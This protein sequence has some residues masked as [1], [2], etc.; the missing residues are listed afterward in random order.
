MSS[1]PT[2][3]RG[4]TLLAAV[5]AVALALAPAIAEAQR[6]GG[7][8]G[9]RGSRTYSA[10]PPTQT[11]PSTAQ[12]LQRTQ[13][14]PTA[15]ATAARPG[16]PAAATPSPAR[17]GFMGGLMGGLIG[18][19][20]AGM[21]FGGGLFGGLNGFAGF[22]G[23]L[24]Q[25]LLIGGLVYLI[26]RLVRGARAPRPALAGLPQGMARTANAGPGPMPMGGGAAP[27]PS[28]EIGIGDQDYQAF[29]RILQG[30]NDA[31]TRQDPEAMR[32]I[33][34][35]EMVAAFGEDLGKLQAKG[36]RS[37]VTEVRLEQGDL[38]EAWREGRLDYAT[39]AMRFSQID[40]TRR[41]AD[42]QIVRGDPTRRT[43]ATEVWTF[44]RPA[45]GSWTLSAI[46]QAA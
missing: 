40:V 21:L 24:L 3:R 8:A 2:T 7:G 33:A 18:V 44:V 30:V 25:F 38:A 27:A 12:P 26:V 35:D 15:P 36:L 42:G 4:A 39:V 13:T 34:T 1:T 5:A 16:A 28:A 17:S 9:S 10:P 32:R 31:W 22:L 23:L 41:I 43:E 14:A 46:Q 11:A 20:I 45:G 37:E 29:E 19:G 6:G